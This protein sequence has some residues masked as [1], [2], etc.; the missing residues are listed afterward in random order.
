MNP[1]PGL[2][3]FGGGTE[4]A[5]QGSEEASGSLSYAVVKT[6]EGRLKATISSARAI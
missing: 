2:G 5:P 6:C 3:T 1:A 4:R